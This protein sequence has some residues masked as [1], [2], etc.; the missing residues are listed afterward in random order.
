MGSMVRRNVDQA[1]PHLEWVW[2]AATTSG[3]A[4]WTWLWMAKA[5]WL[6]GQSPST[7]APLWSTQIRSDTRMRSKLSPNG[8]TQNSSGCSGSWAVTCPATPSLKPNRPKRR[9]VAASRCLRCNRSSSTEANSGNVWGVGWGTVAV[10]DELLE[11]WAT[12]PA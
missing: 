3:R 10:I 9:N 11:A 1:R 5:A 8:L 2:A 6:T 12:G 7:T 4:W